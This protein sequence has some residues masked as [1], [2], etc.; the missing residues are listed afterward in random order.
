M[1]TDSPTAGSRSTAGEWHMGP[2]HDD[3]GEPQDKKVVEPPVSSS[4]SS[5]DPP[6]S[7][8]GAKGSPA[9]LTTLPSIATT[10]KCHADSPLFEIA[11]VI[12]NLG[13]SDWIN[14]LRLLSD[15]SL[16]MMQGEL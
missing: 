8:D 14:F 13:C 4:G 15:K 10:G 3:G 1:V 7:E 9:L 5:H 6:I 12:D 11:E 2:P 16:Q